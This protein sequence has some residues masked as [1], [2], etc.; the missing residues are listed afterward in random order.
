[1]MVFMSL[2]ICTVAGSSCHVVVPVYQS[3]V[4]TSACMTAGIQM[5]PSWE[6][7]HPGW[8]VSKVRCTMGQRP[9]DEDAS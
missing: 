8:K 7:A 3:F 6:E 2:L 5:M 1:M 4:G 9:K